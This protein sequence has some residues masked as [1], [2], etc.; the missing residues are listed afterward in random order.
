MLK[1]DGMFVRDVATDP[2]SLALVRSINE[3]GHAMGKQTVAEFVE[4]GA[5]LERLQELGVDFVQGYHVGRPVLAEGLLNPV[6]A[7]LQA[8]G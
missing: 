6:A 8:A 4:D 7:P 1:I 3:V 5:I 2:T